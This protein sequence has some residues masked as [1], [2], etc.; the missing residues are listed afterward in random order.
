MKYA[1]SLSL[2]AKLATGSTCSQ[3]RPRQVLD[4]FAT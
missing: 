2:A 4:K 3:S 1:L